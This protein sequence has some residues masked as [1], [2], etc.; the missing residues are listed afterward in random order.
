VW[1]GNQGYL[2]N[3]QCLIKRHQFSTSWYHNPEPTPI[4]PL[5]V[6]D[7]PPA[8]NSSPTDHSSQHPN[9]PT[10]KDIVIQLGINYNDKVLAQCTEHFT[11]QDPPEPETIMLTEAMECAAQQ[12]ADYDFTLLDCDPVQISSATTSTAVTVP[13]DCSLK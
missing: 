11:T 8:Y 13:R 4:L 5:K 7:P 1:K 10:D 9:T 2:T 6:Q 3:N 12:I